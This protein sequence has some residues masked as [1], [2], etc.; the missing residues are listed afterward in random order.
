VKKPEKERSLAYLNP[1]V[2]GQWHPTRNGDLKPIDVYSS[3]KKKVWWKCP[4]ADDHEW[5]ASVNNRDFGRGCPFCS[6]RK[7]A[8]SNCLSTLSPELSTEWH[9]SKNG[10]LTPEM[11][12]IGSR[13]KVW[14]KCPKG[15]DHEW[16]YWIGDRVQGD[17]CPICSGRK[18]VLSNCLTTLNPELASQWHPSKNDPLTPFDVGQS[19]GKK[20]WWKCPEGDD[21]EW[22]ASINNRAGGRDCPIC[23][24][25]KVVPSNCMATTHPEIVKQWHPTKNGNTTPQTVVAG[26]NKKVWWKCDKGDDHE[27]KQT[28]SHQAKLAGGYCPYCENRLLSH[29]NSL[30]TIDPSLA[31]QWHPARNG[32]LTP[33]KIRAISPKKVWWKC[34]KGD[35]H[36]WLISPSARKTSGCPICEG[37]KVVPSNSLATTHPE[38]AKYWHP[39]KNGKLTPGHIVAGSEKMVWWKC[40]KGDDHEWRTV[41]KSVAG[42]TRCPVCSNKTIVQSNC[43]STTHPDL[44]AQ[45]HS[46]KNGQLTPDQIGA[47]SNKQVWW[48]CH[49]GEDH[50]WL[51]KPTSRVTF[52]SQ[53]PFCTLTPQSKQELTIT[54]ELITLFPDINPRGFKTRVEGKLWSIDIYIPTL[55]LGVEF[56]GSYWHKNKRALDKLKTKKLTSKGFNILRVREEPLKKISDSDIISKQ[57]FNAKEITNNILTHIMNSFGLEDVLVKKIKAYISKKKLQNEK[58]LDE[59]IEMILNQKAKK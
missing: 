4:E 1:T 19:V 30:A 58:G 28:I 46:T 20:V 29:T 23:S 17:G 33:D 12:T 26:S 18:I 31:S 5:L 37:L 14:W 54:F 34:P 56:D 36:E 13:K 9:P 22:I 43:L 25:K 24:G 27:W 10:N 50:E 41:A 8:H 42:G 48:K 44:A 3:A 57:P 16:E 52:G 49:R 35:D 45:W 40:P 6:G 39:L 59:Y 51:V 47:G 7:A 55:H 38:A 53:C 11:V 32:L 2:A 15:D 21:H